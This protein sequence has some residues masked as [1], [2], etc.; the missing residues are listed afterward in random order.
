MGNST[1]SRFLY[2]A[3]GFLLHILNRG[4][5]AIQPKPAVSKN[6]GAYR[7]QNISLEVTEDEF[8]T[9][10]LDQLTAEKNIYKIS[11][12]RLVPSCTD[13][14][15]KVAIFRLEPLETPSFLQQENPA[16]THR[17]REIHIDSDFWDLTQLYSVKPNEVK[18]DIVAVSGLNSHAYGSWVGPEV[19]GVKPM[20]LQDFLSRDTDLKYC[21]TMIFGYNTKYKTQGNCRIEDFAKILL[22][23]L[24]KA[25]RSE[26][27]QTRPLIFMGHSLGGIVI[28]HAFFEASMVS[29]YKKIYQSTAAMLFFGVPF[30]GIRLEDVASALET[31]NKPGDQGLRIIQDI[32]YETDR[33]T[34][35]TQWFRKEISDTAKKVYTFYET[36]TTR[37]FIK[38]EVRGY[39]RYGDPITVVD[40]N[41]AELGIQEY[42]EVSPADGDH[43]TIVKLKSEQDRTYTT[44]RSCLARI[45]QKR[46]ALDELELKQLPCAEC[47][48]FNFYTTYPSQLR[49]RDPSQ[50]PAECHPE[51]RKELLQE[52]KEWARDL[53]AERIFWLNGMAGAGK[54]AIA[55]TIAKYF[56]KDD[57]CQ[58]AATFFF[59][60]GENERNS[61]T[62][63][64]TTIAVQLS[65]RIP[66]LVPHIKSAI[67]ENPQIGT[68]FLEQQFEK[69]IS[70]PLKTL[71]QNSKPLIFIIDALDEC[72]EAKEDEIEQI[73]FFLRELQ[74]IGTVPIKIFLASRPESSIRRGFGH[75][76]SKYPNIYKSIKLHDF[77]DISLSTIEGDISLST[78]ES[79]IS[80]F[81]KDKFSEIVSDFN[82]EE[83]SSAHTLEL[84]WPGNKEVQKLV[85]LAAPSFIFAAT[86]TRF[87]GGK[88]PEWNPERKLN[89]VLKYGTTGSP[90]DRTYLPVLR[91]LD[92][93]VDISE[94]Q[95]EEFRQEFREIIGTIV[96]LK[97]PLSTP[98]LAKLLD[99]DIR[100]INGKLVH[101]HSVF[102]IP[103]DFNLPVR[104]LHLSFREFL[105][106]PKKRRDE[107]DNKR[108]DDFW[109][110]ID[111]AKTH[112]MISEKCLN[113]LSKCL[114][115]NICSLDYPGMLR[116]H[117]KQTVIKDNLPK[118]IQYACL[119]WPYHLEHGAIGKPIVDNSAVH[120]FLR[121]YFLNWLEALSFLGQLSQI[122]N[123]IENLCSLV[124]AN[125]GSK[126]SSF[127]NDARR[128]LMSNLKIINEAPLQI[129]SSAIIFS[130]E[131]SIIRETFDM[132]IPKWIT[133]PP[134]MPRFWGPVLQTIEGHKR[135]VDCVVFSPNAKQLASASQD[136][137]VRL[138]DVATGQ[139]LKIFVGH[140]DYRIKR[141]AFIP[142]DNQL[143]SCSSGGTIIG[144]D[145]TT[146]EQVKNFRVL[147]DPEYQYGW[148]SIHCD[149]SSDGKQLVTVMN[150]AKS[151]LW[152][153]TTQRPTT[154]STFNLVLYHREIVFSPDN[155]HLAL[156]ACPSWPRWECKFKIIIW[157]IG[158]R[159]KCHTL[160][161][162]GSCSIAFSPDGKQ[163]VSA[164]ETTVELW[165]V[166]KGQRVKS[167]KIS[168]KLGLYSPIAFSPDGEHL[169]LALDNYKIQLWKTTGQHVE[170]FEGHTSSVNAVAFSPDGERL[171]STSS[172]STIRLWDTTRRTETTQQLSRDKSQ[173]QRCVKVVA[174]SHA[175]KLVATASKDSTIILW[176]VASG[177]QL[178]TLKNHTGSVT[179]IS[180]SPDNKQLASGSDDNT[181]KLWNIAT[182]QLMK[183]FPEHSEKIGAVTFS[184]D[185]KRVA[186]AAWDRT[187]RVW[188]EILAVAFSPDNKQLI[189]SSDDL[190]IRLWNAETGQQIHKLEVPAIIRSLRFSANGRYLE[191]DRGG[192]DISPTSLQFPKRLGRIFLCDEWIMRGGQ[193][194]LWL[195]PD[196][197][198]SASGFR[199]NR[200]IIGARSGT[201]T[202][203]EFPDDTE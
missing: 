82:N 101:L 100:Q 50:I 54:S 52:I 133:K 151:I 96:I 110:W 75:L 109:F 71:G 42:E 3:L 192:I 143:M 139:Q 107:A 137:T 124:D 36:R 166:A 81:L 128:F 24:D 66:A 126:I 203:F 103:T 16:F 140:G 92:A 35:T 58:L 155:K 10:F 142:E 119:Y 78:I 200:L 51:T 134:R 14:E 39:G 194:Y 197:R 23:E 171:A 182:G 18:M 181:V 37:K 117:V 22:V 94:S 180:F 146:K 138:W 123:L 44:V 185:G 57:Q 116:E 186:S 29:M 80:I 111:E 38:D 130:P 60:R 53:Q 104:L 145:L 173:H 70:Q 112:T 2:A 85:K 136:G 31:D 153:I 152:D 93:D 108:N 11:Q 68:G 64:F 113:L 129:Y 121:K 79:D 34:Q 62:L 156:V 176:N 7:A 88:K 55:R 191:T 17:G 159:E 67:K 102:N 162:L 76:S 183:T 118:H 26:V 144:W 74:N 1:V 27:E 5:P 28:T 63:L 95:L 198:P 25:R 114:K 105:I 148:Y 160:D 170:T 73:F 6:R 122:F 201:V 56:D 30:R 150:H 40:R 99:I 89:I 158:V 90:M 98:S 47:A 8:K 172:G 178:N 199:K 195:P 179:A 15:T 177:Q 13:A 165:D 193:I 187:V 65:Q 61:A 45:S 154:L 164:N 157:D 168:S 91:Q 125:E 169:A 84:D 147:E 41:S 43:S 135:S 188:S 9:A 149:L 69:L 163:L 174:F 202:F 141:I 49:G 87:I 175:N 32:N 184:N 21:R 19:N 12:L 189:S 97:D 190:T 131:K 59:D 4:K 120:E 33:I 161:T 106:D 83:D 196:Y 72:G 127:L 86:V 132:C 46:M 20:W 115:K 167:F 48:T 77:K